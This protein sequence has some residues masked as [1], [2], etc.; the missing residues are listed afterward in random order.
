LDLFEGHRVYLALEKLVVMQALA[1]GALVAIDELASMIGTDSEHLNAAV[2]R[3][4]W[5]KLVESDRDG[6]LRISPIHPGDYEKLLVVRRLCEPEVVALA[7]KHASEMHRA[8]LFACF[9]KMSSCAGSGSLE[10]FL[11]ADKAFDDL[12]EQACP[13]RY[14]TSVTAQ[15]QA[16]GRR[17]WFATA[18]IESMER[19]IELHVR[20]IRAIQ[21]ANPSAAREAMLLLL[22]GIAEQ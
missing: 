17:L 5:L 13:N 12:V 3:L 1:P 11:E 15:L 16:H 21:Q 22:A 10:R 19:S 14:L 8:A 7:A 18:T 4:Q 20:L 9:E 6:N 2:S